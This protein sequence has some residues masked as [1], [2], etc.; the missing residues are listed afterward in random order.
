MRSGQTERATPFVL[1]REHT[2]I[3]PAANVLG[4]HP[5]TGP[6]RLTP[7]HLDQ[8]RIGF[9][10]D[11]WHA[12]LGD[13]CLLA[14][15]EL[16]STAQVLHVVS[17]DLGYSAPQGPHHVCTVEPSTEPDLDSRDL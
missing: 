5:G 4:L 8:C 12:G 16:E 2:N 1:R 3:G 9:A 11:K 14:A 17:G 10:D 15:N 6:N 7:Q 13:P